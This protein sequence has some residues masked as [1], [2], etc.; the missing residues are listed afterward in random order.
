MAEIEP[1]EIVLGGGNLNNPGE[2][3]PGCRA[4][5]NANAFIGGFRLWDA[6]A[7][8]E[9]E[10]PVSPLCFAILIKPNQISPPQTR[11]FQSRNSPAEPEDLIL[12]KARPI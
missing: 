1:D 12:I 8:L 5:C 9:H 7:N 3:P 11:A 2:L 10:S 6:P 4:G